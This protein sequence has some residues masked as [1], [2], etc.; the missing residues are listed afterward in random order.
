VVVLIVGRSNQERKR[1]SSELITHV[2]DAVTEWTSCI[3]GSFALDGYIEDFVV[4]SSL[5]EGRIVFSPQLLED[6]TE[7]CKSSFVINLA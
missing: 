3:L 6:L 1:S 4:N 5:L 7:D 2:C